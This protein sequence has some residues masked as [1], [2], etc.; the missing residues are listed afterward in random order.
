MDDSSLGPFFEEGRHLKIDLVY[1]H[2]FCLMIL[3]SLSGLTAAHAGSCVMWCEAFDR[4]RRGGIG[5]AAE[6]SRGQ[7]V[8]ADPVLAAAV[9]MCF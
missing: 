4:V 1:L 3:P 7:P 5:A 8:R 6:S 2:G 9:L